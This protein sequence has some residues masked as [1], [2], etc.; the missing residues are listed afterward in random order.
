MNTTQPI[1]KSSVKNI[2]FLS[3]LQA[4][5]AATS[6]ASNQLH[7][8]P[9]LV[10]LKIDHFRFVDRTDKSNK[11][12]TLKDTELN[13]S[14]SKSIQLNSSPPSANNA[15]T[16]PSILST[17]QSGGG[18]GNTNEQVTRPRSTRFSINTGNFETNSQDQEETKTITLTPFTNISTSSSLHKMSYL[19][20]YVANNLR[21][22]NSNPNTNV[23]PFADS[24]WNRIPSSSADSKPTSSY[25]RSTNL[26]Q[27]INSNSQLRAYPSSSQQSDYIA[28][29]PNSSMASANG[30][31][32]PNT[33]EL[34]I[35]DLKLAAATNVQAPLGFQPP[36]GNHLRKSANK[37]RSNMNGTLTPNSGLING[38]SSAKNVNYINAELSLVSRLNDLVAEN[39]NE[40]ASAILLKNRK[41]KILEMLNSMAPIKGIDN[42]ASV[43]NKGETDAAENTSK[44]PK[45]Q[46]AETVN[47]TRIGQ[48]LPKNTLSAHSNHFKALLSQ[49]R[50]NKMNVNGIPIISARTFDMNA[51]HLNYNQEEHQVPNQANNFVSFA[52]NSL[53][54]RRLKF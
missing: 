22:K 5:N 12:K 40:L 36:L 11:L 35:I 17:N 51:R 3:D 20:K 49:Q 1:I 24:C 10:N 31:F 18:S 33:R 34:S 2:V 7:Q 13:D 27:Q 29:K 50:K 48:S 8:N 21:S 45:E 30:N 44:Q 54:I 41:S 43:E 42:A 16:L 52:N 15:K 9:K 14:I 38:R 37:S 23:T 32:Q 53:L 28:K 26:N 4:K 46:E 47:V 6:E 39:R 19:K 25:M